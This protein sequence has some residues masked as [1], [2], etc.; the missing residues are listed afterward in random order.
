VCA[1]P[2]VAGDLGEGGV[3]VADERIDDSVVDI[4]AST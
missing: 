3:T 2:D 4:V 1:E